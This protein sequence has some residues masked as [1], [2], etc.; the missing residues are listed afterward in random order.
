MFLEITAAYVEVLFGM[1]DGDANKLVEAISMPVLMVAQSV[2]S[3]E[4]VKEIGEEVEREER[5]QKTK[6]IILTVLLLAFFFIPIAGEAVLALGWTGVTVA[7]IA[8]TIGLA[9]DAALTAYE[10]VEDPSRPC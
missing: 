10:A 1:W 5:E 6:D 7:R 8:T 9:G 4:Q 3:M 2:E